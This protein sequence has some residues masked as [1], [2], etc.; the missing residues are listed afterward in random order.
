MQVYSLG[1]LGEDLHSAHSGVSDAEVGNF[2]KIVMAGKG[3]HM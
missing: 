2:W 1:E 3:S